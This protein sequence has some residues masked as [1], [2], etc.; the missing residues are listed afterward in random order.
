[1]TVVENITAECTQCAQGNATDDL[2]LVIYLNQ[3]NLLQ[4]LSE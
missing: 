4:A 3:K 2:K 1:M